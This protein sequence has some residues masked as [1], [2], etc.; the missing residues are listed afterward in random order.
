MSAI[1][2]KVKSIPFLMKRR[3]ATENIEAFIQRREPPSFERDEDV[4][5]FRRLRMAERLVDYMILLDEQRDGP[6]RHGEVWYWGN[7]VDQE[8][9]MTY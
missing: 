1:L 2:R 5:F 6:R 8:F 9:P 4:D 7:D 3:K